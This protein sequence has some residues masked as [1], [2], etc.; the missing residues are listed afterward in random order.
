M[1][2]RLGMDQRGDPAQKPAMKCCQNQH[3]GEVTAAAVEFQVRLI[4][5]FTAEGNSNRTLSRRGAAS[6]AAAVCS[7][8]LAVLG[9]LHVVDSY[10]LD[11]F[12]R[13]LDSPSK[14]WIYDMICMYVY[15]YIIL[16]IIL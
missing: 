12:G 8:I 10:L 13:L 9:G 2:I 11:S 1:H 15:I 6:K 5:L 14:T 3:R 16:Y 4:D 7:S